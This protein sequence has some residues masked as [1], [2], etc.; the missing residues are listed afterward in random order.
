MEPQARSHTH[1]A[2]ATLLCSEP[3]VGRRC[4][5]RSIMTP[6]MHLL[7][8]R[9]GGVGCGLVVKAA[10][11]VGTRNQVTFWFGERVRESCCGLL[12]WAPGGG[13]GPED[14]GQGSGYLG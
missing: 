6:A 7:E 8:G 2:H 4:D 3:V 11:M 12:A 13:L 14:L 9:E 1:L 10:V 5:A